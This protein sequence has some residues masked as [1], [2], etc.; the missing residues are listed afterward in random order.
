MLNGDLWQQVET[1]V[2]HHPK[3]RRTVNTLVTGP[4]GDPGTGAW[5]QANMEDLHEATTGGL[6]LLFPD[7]L[8]G[9]EFRM[10]EAALYDAEEVREEID[11]DHPQFGRW[12]PVETEADGEGY[13]A[14]VGELVEEL[15]RLEAEAG[16]QFVVTRCQ[17]SGPQESDPFE[18]NLERLG[19]E[20]QSR[21]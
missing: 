15:Q 3:T 18:V 10:T 11:A 2:T 6:S 9:K 16:E 17:K 1:L 19:P 8:S 4:G 7:E 21:L 5:R 20:D 12:L 13:A 14:A